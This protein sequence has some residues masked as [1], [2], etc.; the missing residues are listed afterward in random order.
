MTDADD[1]M[2]RVLALRPD[3]LA[4][5]RAAFLQFIGS[6]DAGE[7][8]DRRAL[9]PSDYETF[10]PEAYDDET[11]ALQSIVDERWPDDLRN[12]KTEA[13]VL[14]QERQ[15]SRPKPPSDYTVFK[16]LYEADHPKPDRTAPPEEQAAWEWGHLDAYYE[17]MEMLGALARHR[18]E[19]GAFLDRRTA[20][21][22]RAQGWASDRFDAS[23]ASYHLPVVK[24][25]GVWPPIH[26]DD[27]LL[28][29]GG[30]DDPVEGAD[31][32]RRRAENAAY[33]RA[34]DLYCGSLGWLESL[35]LPRPDG[36][37]DE[38]YLAAYEAGW[39]MQ[40]AAE[41]S[42]RPA[43]IARTILDIKRALPL[44]DEA[45]LALDSVDAE[46]WLTPAAHDHLT[47]L[48]V[49]ARD[50]LQDRLVEAREH[51]AAL[52]AVARRVLGSATDE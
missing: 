44:A 47:L 6:L 19:K 23:D 49:A 9:R 15:D 21:L 45:L 1:L 12:L 40:R 36:G 52:W 38:V 17:R 46:P 34:Q 31:L 10:D 43:Y 7:R 25:Q 18:I 16:E 30:L 42:F 26:P 3:D 22:R 41:G 28:E 33:A 8:M 13:Q 4:A 29:H 2:A 27:D 14:A 37:W 20:S 50:A 35:P 32:R 5:F 48:L 11:E 24:G 51:Y 39:K